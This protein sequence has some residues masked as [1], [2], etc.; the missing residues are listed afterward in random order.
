MVT[1]RFKLS[2][3]GTVE[4]SIAQPTEFK[5]VLEI[6]SDTTGT[7]LGSVMAVRNGKVLN[8][9]ELVYTDDVIDVFPAISGG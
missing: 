2:E 5:K 6:C 1:L 9:Q 7:R 4:L 3:L 8:L